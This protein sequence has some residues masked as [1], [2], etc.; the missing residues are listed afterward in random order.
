MHIGLKLKKKSPFI[1]LCVKAFIILFVFI[2]IMTKSVAENNTDLSFIVLYVR[3]A[4]TV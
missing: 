3:G 2:I 1:L 4:G